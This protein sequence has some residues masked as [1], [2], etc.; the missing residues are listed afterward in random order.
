AYS[1]CKTRRLRVGWSK[2]ARAG[3][4][5]DEDGLGRQFG[6][7]HRAL[8]DELPRVEAVVEAAAREELRVRALLDDA[9]PVEDQDPGRALYRRQPVREPD[10]R[11]ATHHTVQGLLNEG[12]TLVFERV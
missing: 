11:A 10:R 9:A 12:L 6:R 5:S 3:H 1:G 7:R 4:G 8:V 2:A